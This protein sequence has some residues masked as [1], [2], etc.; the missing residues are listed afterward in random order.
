MG[1]RFFSVSSEGPP[2]L[3]ASYDSQGDAEDLFLPGSSRVPIESPL[4][5]RKGMRRTYS[6]PGPHGFFKSFIPLWCGQGA[7]F[8]L[9]LIM[10]TSGLKQAISTS[11]FLIV[12]GHLIGRS[13]GWDHKNVVRFRTSYFLLHSYSTSIVLLACIYTCSTTFMTLGCFRFFIFHR[14]FTNANLFED[15]RSL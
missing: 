8:V 13:F 1:P 7:V 4:T 10:W 6:Y 5:T 14:E 11:N 15:R 9:Q 2:H 3:I 12:R